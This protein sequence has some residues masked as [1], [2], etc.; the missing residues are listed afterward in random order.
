MLQTNMERWNRDLYILLKMIVHLQKKKSQFWLCREG[1]PK[2]GWD[3][4]Y[5]VKT[6]CVLNYVMIKRGKYRLL[7]SKRKIFSVG[8]QMA[9][10][11]WSWMTVTIARLKATIKLI[12]K[13]P[14]DPGVY[15]IVRE[16]QIHTNRGLVHRKWNPMLPVQ[17]MNSMLL[18]GL[19]FVLKKYS[20]LIQDQTL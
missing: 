6:L 14:T 13:F 8:K 19:T 1:T 3:K 17:L 10:C 5:H 15:I 7:V 4:T 18:K 12:V 16:L 11:V 9:K 20:D 2:I